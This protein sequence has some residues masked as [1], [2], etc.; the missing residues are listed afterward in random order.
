MIK[1]TAFFMSIYFSVM[2][3]LGIPFTPEDLQPGESNEI[4]ITTEQ[5]ELFKEIFET[6]TQWLASL[7]L[8][9]GAIPMTYSPNGELRVNP[10]FS[11]F[12]VLALLDNAEKC[13]NTAVKYMDWHFAHLNTAEE[14]FNGLDGTIYDYVV[15]MKN[16][17]IIEEKVSVPENADSYDSTDSYAATFL[18]VV[19]KYVKK[20]GDT[21][22]ITDH[23]EDLERI[24]NVMCATLHNGLTFAKP[25]HKVKYLMD[26]CEVYEGA[27]AAA[28]IFGALADNGDTGYQAVSEKYADLAET[29]KEK[30][31]TKLWNFVGGYYIAGMTYLH[32]P[33]SIFSWNTYYPCATA[34]L[35]PITCGII[36]P[37]TDRAKKLYQKFC[38]SYNW[39]AFEYPDDFYWGHNV[40]T[41]AMMNDVDSVAVYM[42]NYKVIMEN[43]NWPLYNA[44]SARVALAAHI[45]LEKI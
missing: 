39:E 45:M 10:Y 19:D 25:N 35:F 33:T 38:D 28:E 31:N 34:Q 5:A 42:T 23:A 3:L 22:Y 30:I 17:E 15:T 12:A 4:T 43:H 9:N 41:A 20:T 14:D 27:V 32:I 11:D 44:D 18:R 6:E 16:G 1:I 7:Q 24:A 40:L 29:V 21:A 2:A 8:P 13:S 26:N 36:E 37:E